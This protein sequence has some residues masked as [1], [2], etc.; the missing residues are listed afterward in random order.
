[1]YYKNQRS[2]FYKRVFKQVAV[3]I[4][5]TAVIGLIIF[6]AGIPILSFVFNTDLGMYRVELLI[7]II[8]GFLYALQYYLA[9][10]VTV[11]KRQKYMLPGYIGAIAICFLF[12]KRLVENTGLKGV[13]IMY[14]IANGIMALYLM[15]LLYKRES[16]AIDKG[17]V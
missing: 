9:I 15:A 4:A 7:L 8:G 2:A 13:A 6:F 16:V 17:V 14:V 11:M 10:P 3:I 12:Q 5:T 1:M